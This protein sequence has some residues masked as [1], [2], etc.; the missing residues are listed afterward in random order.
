MTAGEHTALSATF[1]W[2]S[3]TDSTAV[4]VNVTER[5][6][7][8]LSLRPGQADAQL[9]ETLTV[10]YELTNTG[11]AADSVRLVVDTR[12]GMVTG[13]PAAVLLGPFETVTGE[14]RVRPEQRALE[15]TV[16]GILVTAEGRH[17]AAHD[18][19]A[20]PVTQGDGLFE[21]WARI[22]TSVFVGTSLYPGNDTRAATPAYGFESAGMV[23]PGMRLAVSAHSAP[24]GSER[25]RVPWISDGTTIPGRSLDGPV[26]RGSGTIVHAHLADRRIRAPGSGRAGRR[27]ERQIR[28]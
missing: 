26:R 1:A 3:G 14:F 2:A 5:P 18:R 9:G 6:G 22:P 8:T 15:G 24:A 17:T 16:E 7:L 11:N 4:T 19:I 23:R 21:S 12:L 13:S 20:L 28:R 10:A 25:V 27:P